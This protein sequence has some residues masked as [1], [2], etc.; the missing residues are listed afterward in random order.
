MFGLGKSK[1]TQK[2]TV[3]QNAPVQQAQPSQ[4]SKPPRPSKISFFSRPRDCRMY[5]E[6]KDDPELQAAL[7]EF[8]K[9]YCAAY[10]ACV[11][12]TYGDPYAE[13]FEIYKKIDEML[14]YGS[15]GLN[16]SIGA[17]GQ[18]FR[19][20]DKFW[21]DYQS[22]R[23]DYLGFEYRPFVDHDGWSTLDMDYFYDVIVPE[24][25]RL[26]IDNENDRINDIERKTHIERQECYNRSTRDFIHFKVDGYYGA[27][28]DA[29]DFVEFMNRMSRELLSGT[30]P[31]IERDKVSG[32]VKIGTGF[33]V[34]SIANSVSQLAHC[35]SPGPKQEISFEWD[36]K[37]IALVG[38]FGGACM[39]CEEDPQNE[40]YPVQPARKVIFA[41]LNWKN[42]I[43]QG[44]EREINPSTFKRDCFNLAKEIV[45]INKLTYSER[46]NSIIVDEPGKEGEL[47]LVYEDKRYVEGGGK[48][49]S[50]VLEE[51]IELCEQ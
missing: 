6:P 51:E 48:E 18:L 45:M 26:G 33:S 11:E 7:I 15:N 24:C 31:T 42:E 16:S 37:D 4:P 28:L 12:E 1:K 46:V 20:R 47:Y 50:E 19:F 2:V 23:Y 34:P 8:R 5:G 25:R 35:A 10:R 17:I 39:Y 36:K 14:F 9:A 21:K 13:Y 3:V 38:Y 49:I 43:I 44:T 29:H 40:G 32:K 41:K 27:V 22:Y 30:F